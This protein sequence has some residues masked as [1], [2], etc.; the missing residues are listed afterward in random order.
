MPHCVEQQV[1]QRCYAVL[2]GILQLQ[3]GFGQLSLGLSQVSL[4]CHKF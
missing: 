2:I 1:F 4:K 3:F